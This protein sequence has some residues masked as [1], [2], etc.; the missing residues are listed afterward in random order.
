MKRLKLAEETPTPK[1]TK[2]NYILTKARNDLKAF[3]QMEASL[4]YKLIFGEG[5]DFEEEGWWTIFTGDLCDDLYINV[6]V[7]NSYLDVEERTYERREMSEIIV[8]LDG[9]VMVR[10]EDGN[11]WD[12]TDI[13]ISELATIADL[14]ELTYNNKVKE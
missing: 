6:E 3:I 13:T 9:T 12:D 4:L 11:E 14:L 8:L 1:V 5:P 7:D 2:A 10:D